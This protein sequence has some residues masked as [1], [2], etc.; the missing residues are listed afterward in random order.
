MEK[1][2]IATELGLPEGQVLSWS[3]ESRKLLFDRLKEILDLW[4][5]EG[6][7]KLGDVPKNHRLVNEFKETSRKIGFKVDF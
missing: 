4:E 3:F 7:C 5:V 1:R 2:D 6:F